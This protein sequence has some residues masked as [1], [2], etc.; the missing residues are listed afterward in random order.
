MESAVRGER[1]EVVA[2]A[3][4]IRTDVSGGVSEEHRRVVREGGVPVG[5]DAVAL[6]KPLNKATGVDAT[7]FG[8]EGSANEDAVGDCRVGGENTPPVAT[9]EIGH[10]CLTTCLAKKGE[11]ARSRAGDEHHVGCLPFEVG[12][13]RLEVLSAALGDRVRA[14][15]LT[16]E[17]ADE[18][19]SK[20]A[21]IG[22]VLVQNDGP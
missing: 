22:I 18:G 17:A 7:I 19:V 2:Y 3:S 11:T 8:S 16:F 5:R 1:G 10:E 13:E 6:S 12:D 21:A 14:H 9:D 15:D 4:A 20:S